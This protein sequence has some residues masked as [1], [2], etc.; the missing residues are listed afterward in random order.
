MVLFTFLLSLLPLFVSL[1]SGQTAQPPVGW[2]KFTYQGVAIDPAKLRY[3]PTNE[4]IFPSVFHAGKYL[5]KPL[6][7]WYLYYAPH[8]DPGGISLAYASSLDGPWTEYA[9]NPLIKNVV[10]N[11]YSVPHVSSPDAVWNPYV[12]G[13][14]NGKVMLYFH[15]DNGQTRWAYSEDGVNFKYG[16]L[17]ITNKMGGSR[18]TESSYARVFP[19]PDK[20]QT[21]YRWAMFYM[22]N[23]IDNIRRIRLAESFDGKTWTVS[24]NYVVAPG[25]E[26][27][28]NVSGADLWEWNGQLY[29]IYHASSGKIYARTI[30]PTLRNVGALPIVLHQSSGVGADVGRCAAPQVVTNGTSTYLYYESGA[31]LSADIA[32]AKMTGVTS[33]VNIP[34]I[35]KTVSKTVSQTV[36]KTVSQTVSQTMSKTV[37]QTMSKTVSK[38]V[39]F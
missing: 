39:T 38:T 15:G 4:V 12:V 31:R 34:V 8:D 13:K 23:E 25:P 21:K 10:P 17:S 24:P 18:V 11:K 2:P 22:G 32:F 20:T 6:G 19:H 35:P 36:S 1:A 30:D 33:P 9:K 29:V 28:K 7:Q 3:N 14:D 27:G 5:S 37:S 26:E 16:G